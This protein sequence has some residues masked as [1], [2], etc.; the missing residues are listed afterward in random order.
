MIK[1]SVIVRI[2]VE[3]IHRWEKCP[4]EE[5]SYLKHYHRHMFFISGKHY[6]SHDD[7]DVEFIQLS[8]KI[9]KYLRDKYFSTEAQCLFFGEMSCE[10]IAKELLVAFNLYECEVNEDGEGGAIIKLED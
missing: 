2:K 1:T 5:V 10:M 3:G 6:V 4:I 9:R 8:H 7:R